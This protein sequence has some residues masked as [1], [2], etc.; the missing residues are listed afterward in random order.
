MTETE[1]IATFADRADRH[2]T[3]VIYKIVGVAVLIAAL[4]WLFIAG[5]IWSERQSALHHGLIDGRNLAAAFAV[6]LTHTLD[7]IEEIGRAHV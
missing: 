3:R 6:E 7:H 5:L 4:M 2:A 1:E